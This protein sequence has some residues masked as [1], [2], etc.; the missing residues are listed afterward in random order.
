MNKLERVTYISN[1][2]NELYPSPP[3]PLKHDSIFTLLIAV[4]LSAQ[5]TDKRVNQIS[6]KL[7]SKAKTPKEM[8]SLGTHN[9]QKIIKPC[10]LAPKKSQAIYELS[11]ILL[12][13]FSGEVPESFKELESLPGV[14]H[15]TAS[16]VMGQGFKH[17]TFPVDTH[18]H[19][20]AQRWRLSNGISVKKTEKDLKQAFPISEWNRLHIQFILYGRE[21]CKARECYGIGCRIC[22]NCYPKRKKP[23]TTKKA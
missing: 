9:I 10:G 17:P 14:G 16:V 6:P 11:K 22:K 18:V 21:Y 15:K 13:D 7:F 19:R 23:I 8:S 2:L 1:T 20:L 5:C 4:I 12:K 3:I